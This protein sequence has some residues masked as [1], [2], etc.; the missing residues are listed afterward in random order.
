MMPSVASSASP[1]P[2]S[3]P[4]DS[5][6]LN[7]ASALSW[8]SSSS[9]ESL[10]SASALAIASRTPKSSLPADSSAVTGLKIGK[11][12]MMINSTATLPESRGCGTPRWSIRTLSADI[13]YNWFS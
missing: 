3:R 11:N 8:A 1:S 7:T 6:A 4:L 9:S 5:K 2:I 13:N 10:C 12:M